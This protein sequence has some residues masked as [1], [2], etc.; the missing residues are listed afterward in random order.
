ML[1][2]RNTATEALQIS[3]SYFNFNPRTFCQSFAGSLQFRRNTYFYGNTALLSLTP[4]L[5]GQVGI[6]FTQNK[7]NFQI[8]Q[9]L[10]SK[11]YSRDI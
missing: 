10:L 5:N 2:K 9:H 8:I 6:S 1:E 7:E 4:K 3:L 11:R